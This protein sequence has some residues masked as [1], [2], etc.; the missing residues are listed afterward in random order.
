MFHIEFENDKGEKQLAWQNSWGLTIRVI[1]A[2]IMVHGDN[3]GLVLPPRVAPLQAVIVPIFGKD[4]SGVNKVAPELLK[5]LQDAGVRV[6]Y[7]DRDNYNPGWKYNH[8]ELKGIPIRIEVIPPPFPFPSLFPS[9]FL[10][11]PLSFPFRP[12]LPAL[13]PPKS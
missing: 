4:N 8:W 13:P 2:M 11:F 3:N 5:V 1:G 7:D 12:F 6:K 9:S 10:F